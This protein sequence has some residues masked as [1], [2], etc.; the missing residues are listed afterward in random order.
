MKINSKIL[1][2]VF[3]LLFISFSIFFYISL[4][5][6]Q[7]SL[8][9]SFADKLIVARDSKK[10][11]LEK[12]LSEV[13]SDLVYFTEMPVI[14][15]NL[16]GFYGEEDFS[17]SLG[18]FDKYLK[19]LQIVYYEKNPYKN[20]EKLDNFFYDDNFDQNKISPDILDEIY[21]YN[22][23]HEQ[24]NPLLR[25]L[26]NIK[27]IYYDIYYITPDGYIL[28][29]VKKNEDFGTNIENGKY[30]DTVLGKLYN[31][32][33]Q[34]NDDNVHFSD[35]ESYNIGEEEH[36]FFAGKRVLYDGENVG[37]LIVRILDETF[38]NIFLDKSGMGETG[39][40]YIVSEDKIMRNNLPGEETILKQKVETD[41]VEKALSGE[42]GW[43]IGENYKG[44]KVIVAYAPFKYK[45]IKWAF[46][47]E[48]STKEAFLASEKIKIV[49]IITSI[50]ILII[51][52]IISIIFAKKISKPLM[53][54]SKKVDRFATG[55]FTVEF[56]SKGKD[57]T[58]IIAKSLQNMSNNLKETVKWLLEAGNK[59]EESSEILGEVAERTMLA[60]EE[61]LEKARAIEE[62]AENAA[63]TT[64]E[65]TS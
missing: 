65:L 20:R 24:I 13:K 45:E 59:I 6:S 34:S 33:K 40:T 41:Y 26:I 50:I 12:T 35:I 49:L 28:Y 53:E 62:N 60:N 21:Q 17:K 14:I 27:A 52:V 54:L 16:N 5:N 19:D 4:T 56:K 44:E 32:L 29:S 11:F 64:E 3:S 61:A 37:Y 63:A 22:A 7:N 25:K 30:K 18:G 47:S 39:K 38:E 23:I 43:E 8:Q 36:G 1:I 31:I 46:I 48:V 55:D 42:T 9:Q 2:L 57:E 10:A 51:S 58:A 15:E